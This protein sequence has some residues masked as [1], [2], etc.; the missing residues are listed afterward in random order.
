VRRV[1]QV[2]R[3]MCSKL[4]APMDSGQ[5]SLS[6]ITDEM[7]LNVPTKP[8]TVARTEQGTTKH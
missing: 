3:V 6:R 4:E 2:F 5:A 1:V 7:Q 8:F